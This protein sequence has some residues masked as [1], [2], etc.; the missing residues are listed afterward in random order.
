MT[1]STSD[2]SGQSRGLLLNEPRGFGNGL[3]NEALRRVGVVTDALDVKAKRSQDW[4]PKRC[5]RL[6]DVSPFPAL[7]PTHREEGLAS[8]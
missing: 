6:H 3:S 8:E 4:H 5:R 2:K 1:L 7:L